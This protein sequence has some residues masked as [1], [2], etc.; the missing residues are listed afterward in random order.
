MGSTASYLT[1][2]V[3]VHSAMCAYEPAT[4]HAY[5]QQP[6]IVSPVLYLMVQ[7]WLVLARHTFLKTGE[8]QLC[9]SS[10]GNVCRIPDI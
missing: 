6:Y 2:V 1:S 10:S 5:I 7:W 9:V 4:P 3:S 8:C